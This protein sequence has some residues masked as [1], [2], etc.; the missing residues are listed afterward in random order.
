MDEVVFGLTVAIFI[1][2]FM[3]FSCWCKSDKSNKDYFANNS[4][5]LSDDLEIK[6]K[7]ENILEY[8]EYGVGVENRKSLAREEDL[9]NVTD[10]E[11]YNEIIQYMSIDP[12]IHQSHNNFTSDIGISTTGASMRS[13]TDHPNDLNSW[14]LRPPNYRDASVQE[15]ARQEPSEYVD[16]M[17]DRN[18]YTI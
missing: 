8:S 13:T 3:L 11:D 4:K 15:G 12:E 18:Y 7:D 9:K 1:V 14:V 2:L 10:Y 5:N 17:R 6:V 16:Q